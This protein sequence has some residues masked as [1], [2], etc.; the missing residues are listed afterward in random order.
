[1]TDRDCYHLRMQF[2]KFLSRK[3]TWCISNLF[4]TPETW[5]SLNHTF[6]S[7]HMSAR[8]Q[9]WGTVQKSSHM[10]D[11]KL[12]LTCE[13]EAEPQPWWELQSQSLDHRSHGRHTTSTRTLPDSDCCRTEVEAIW[14]VG[15]LCELPASSHWLHSRWEGREQKCWGRIIICPASPLPHFSCTLAVPGSHAHQPY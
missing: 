5:R 12:V 14:R 3:M 4:Y 7:K 11:Q 9:D 8:C 13:Y 10:A 6:F 2:L 15:T 1:M